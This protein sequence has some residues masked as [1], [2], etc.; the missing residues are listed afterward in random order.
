[1][2]SFLYCTFYCDKVY[3]YLVIEIV[4]LGISKIN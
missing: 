1:M 3:A 4:I 2:T